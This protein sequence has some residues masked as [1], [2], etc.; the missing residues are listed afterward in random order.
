VIRVAP[1][2]QRVIVGTFMILAAVVFAVAPL[3]VTFRSAG[4]VLFSYLAFGI[5]GMPFAYLAALL[6]PPIGL[7]TGDADWLVMLP[8]VLSGNL[9]AMLALEFAWRYPALALSPLLLV[10]PAIFVQAATR[11]EL[12]AIELPW[13]EAQG[14]WIVLHLLV[15]AFGI[16][17]AFVLD[18]RRGRGA[19]TERRAAARPQ[20]RPGAGAEAT[21]G[22]RA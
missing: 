2:P 1:D 15:A 20:V 11:R 17:T 4:V 6:A 12:F 18:R 19:E 22:R 21:R 5:G 7:I 8:I 14:T 13:D 16:L 3:S 9:L 10:T